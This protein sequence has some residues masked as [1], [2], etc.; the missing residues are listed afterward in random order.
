MGRQLRS[1]LDLL[2]PTVEKRVKQSQEHQKA[3]HD[4]RAKARVFSVGDMV[5]ARNFSSG[6]TWLE[7]TIVEIRGPLSF[8]IELG[9]GRIVRRHVDQIRANHATGVHPSVT[10]GEADNDAADSLPSPTVEDGEPLD[11][12][13][14]LPFKMR[15]LVVQ[16]E[17]DILQIVSCVNPRREECGSWDSDVIGVYYLLAFVLLFPCSIVLSCV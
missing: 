2:H 15:S 12:Q 9:D 13:I 4:R 17:C 16:S 6:P 14:L 8:R 7:G 11:P 1:H 3:G 5:Y 10:P